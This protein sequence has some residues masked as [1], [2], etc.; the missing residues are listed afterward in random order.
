MTCLDERR[1]LDVHFG[2]APAATTDHVAAC[3]SCAAR[4]RLIRHDLA[5]ID[6][7]LRTAPP[8]PAARLWLVRRWAPLAL[9]AAMLLAVVV[10]RMPART[11]VDAG[12]DTLALAD[13]ITSAMTDDVAFDDASTDPTGEPSTC[14]WGDPFLGVGCEEPAV[15]RIAWR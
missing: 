8:R 12:D 7:V 9:A 1:L 14:T 11:P 6:A 13:E 2:D 15:M 5:R 3:P 4:V 10:H